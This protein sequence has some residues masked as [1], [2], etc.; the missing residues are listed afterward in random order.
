MTSD[1]CIYPGGASDKE[2]ANAEDIRDAGLIPG[3]GG[4]HCNP[5]QN[6]CLEDSMDRGAWWAIVHGVAKS[7]TR[8]KQLSTHESVTSIIVMLSCNFML[9]FFTFIF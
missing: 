5:L 6:S 7:W 3:P 9:L 4:G 8:L 1:I 2:S